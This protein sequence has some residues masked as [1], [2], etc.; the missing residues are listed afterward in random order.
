MTASNVRPLNGGSCAFVTRTVAAAAKRG[1]L[2][3]A[4]ADDDRTGYDRNDEVIAATAATADHVWKLRA[5]D[6]K[7]AVSAAVHVHDDSD[8][9]EGKD[10][11]ESEKTISGM[12]KKQMRRNSQQT[13]STS[14]KVPV[15]EDVGQEL[16][17]RQKAGLAECYPLIDEDGSGT[18]SVLEDILNTDLTTKVSERAVVLI[19]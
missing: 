13:A 8:D 15:E 18:S 4:Y 6:K 16:T 7:A 11:D 2:F 3:A 12:W 10:Q 14:S 17:Q 9:E 5:D 19:V 1:G